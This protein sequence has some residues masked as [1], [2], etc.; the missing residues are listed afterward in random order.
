M[1]IKLLKNWS[2]PEQKNCTFTRPGF[3]NWQ[4][5]L[6]RNISS[7]SKIDKRYISRSELI[8]LATE[9]TSHIGF[10]EPSLKTDTKIIVTGH[11]PIWHH[12]GIF[13]K[14]LVTDR[15]AR[16][17][18]GIAVQLVLDND[19][20]NSS[21][22]VPKYEGNNLLAYETNPLEGRHKEIPAEFRHVPSKV[23]LIRFINSIL[24]NSKDSLCSDIWY[25]ELNCIIQNTQLC[26]NVADLVTQMMSRLYRVLGLKLL[27][28]PVSLM[29]QSDSFYYFVCSVISEPFGFASAYN[30]AISSKI[31]S[32]KL[33]PSQTIRTLETDYLKNIAEL[34]FWIISQ[35][36]K[37]SS[38]YVNPRNNI[39]YI[40]SAD[41][42]IDTIDLSGDKKLQLL[43]ILRKNQLV[44]RPKAV[45]LTLFARLYLADLFVHGTGAGNYEYIT[46]HLIQSYYKIPDTDIGIATATMSLLIDSDC[47]DPKI[48]QE[49]ANYREF[50]FGLFPKY[51]LEKLMNFNE[52]EN[53]NGIDCCSPS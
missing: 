11:Q 34:P 41:K 22:F 42:I 37:R 28:L 3:N 52:V 35:K 6:R 48:L 51:R 7:L 8:N 43:E 17:V 25:R 23:Q 39:L 50:F 44:I 46:D 19:I 53:E 26:R 12:C 10:S 21:M 14:N 15:F 13:A 4:A 1:A 38:L 36:G 2:V 16:Q 9:Y 49:M 30:Q 18:D 32:E 24:T 45:T 29:S 20:C 27:Y 40:G 5:L 47:R 31:K 33:K